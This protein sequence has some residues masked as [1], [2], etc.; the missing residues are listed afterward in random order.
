MHILLFITFI[1]VQQSSLPTFFSFLQLH[2]WHMKVPRSEVKSRAIAMSYTTTTATPDLSHIC[3]LFCSL[4]QS[5]THWGQGPNPH[6]HRGI[7]SLTYWATMETPRHNQ[8]LKRFLD[9]QRKSTI[10]IKIK[11]ALKFS[12]TLSI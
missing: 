8:F 9:C 11:V 1:V 12:F 7:K 10:Q 2:L 3:D 6:P 5:L 4:Q